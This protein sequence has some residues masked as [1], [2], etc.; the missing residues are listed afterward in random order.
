MNVSCLVQ[1]KQRDECGHLS[2]VRR[3]PVVS[4][5]SH[6]LS[7]FA[8]S[9]SFSPLQYPLTLSSEALPSHKRRTA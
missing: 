7:L 2:L 1:S 3:T 5:L 9:L 6:S 4:P 8:L